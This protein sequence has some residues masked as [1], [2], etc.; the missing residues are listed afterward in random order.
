MLLGLVMQTPP[1]WQGPQFQTPRRKAGVGVRHPSQLRHKEPRSRVLGMV[2]TFQKSKFPD[3]SQG[4]ASQTGSSEEGGLRPAVVTV[5]PTHLGVGV[6]CPPALLP[7]VP[8]GADSPPP[9]QEPS[10]PKP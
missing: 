9:P 5:L 1:A 4:P 6:L 7:N 10:S 3:S 2:R 8:V